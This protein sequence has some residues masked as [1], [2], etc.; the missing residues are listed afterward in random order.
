MQH[1]AGDGEGVEVRCRTESFRRSVM[2]WIKKKKSIGCASKL[3]FEL[4]K[5]NPIKK[6]RRL[7]KCSL[8]KFYQE[9]G[10]NQI[11]LV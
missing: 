6:M 9:M 2:V 10:I 3:G 1:R 11:N 7:T 5:Y 4:H 8:G